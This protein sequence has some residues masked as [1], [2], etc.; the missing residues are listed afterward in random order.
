M[1]DEMYYLCFN[2]EEDDYAYIKADLPKYNIE[3]LGL[4][5]DALGDEVSIIKAKMNDLHKWAV[6]IGYQMHPDYLYHLDELDLEDMKLISNSKKQVKSDYKHEP[7]GRVW[8]SPIQE[9]LIKGIEYELPFIGGDWDELQPKDFEYDET[10]GLGKISFTSGEYIHDEGVSEGALSEIVAN[11]EQMKGDTFN[12]YDGDVTIESVYISDGS[13]SFDN[14]EIFCEM[15]FSMKQNVNNSKKGEKMKTRINNSVESMDKFGLH[16]D[17]SNP[18]YDG[19]FYDANTKRTYDVTNDN[20]DVVG[21]ITTTE[22]PRKTYIQAIVLTD[23][24]SK[25][26]TNRNNKL[27]DTIEDAMSWISEQNTSQIN[28]SDEGE[29]PMVNAKQ[30]KKTNYM[31]LNMLEKGFADNV[32]FLE[33]GY[34]ILAN[35]KEINVRLDGKGGALIRN[36]KKLTEVKSARLDDVLTK[37]ILKSAYGHKGSFFKKEQIKNGAILTDPRGKKW[38]INAKVAMEYINLFDQEDCDE[39]LVGLPIL[40]AYSPRTMKNIETVDEE[41]EMI[42][43]KSALDPSEYAFMPKADMIE[44]VGQ[45]VVGSSLCS[46]ADKFAIQSFNEKLDGAFCDKEVKH[47]NGIVNSL[48]THY[49]LAERTSSAI[50][51]AHKQKELKNYFDKKYPE[52]LSRKALT[53]ALA[54]EAPSIFNAC[55]IDEKL[56]YNDTF[57]KMVKRADAVTFRLDNS[58][59]MFVQLDKAGVFSARFRAIPNVEGIKNALAREGYMVSDIQSGLTVT[60]GEDIAPSIIANCANFKPVTEDRV[61]KSSTVSTVKGVMV[62]KALKEYGINDETRVFNSMTKVVIG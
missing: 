8:K 20:G 34:D 35:G 21:T 61:L 45:T 44:N 37:F 59:D 12:L 19:S 26:G 10:T 32:E 9:D 1:N 47:N 60:L 29:T 5:E 18:R 24:F 43:L 15:E 6:D 23:D 13:N 17:G 49:A 33:N 7:N 53:N 54:F 51:S 22:T 16:L 40:N 4:Y 62:T 38:V 55:G 30:M 41:V 3:Y 25:N 50:E 48:R 46:S 39:A 31:L 42:Q 52:G 11:L 2:L 27:F 56:A 28:N 14:Y 36:E 58:R 57:N